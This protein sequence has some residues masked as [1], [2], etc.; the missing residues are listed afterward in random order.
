MITKCRYLLYLSCFL[1]CYLFRPIPILFPA[2]SHKQN[3]S[4][5]RGFWTGRGKPAA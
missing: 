4:Q 1:L 3:V 2:H 5:S